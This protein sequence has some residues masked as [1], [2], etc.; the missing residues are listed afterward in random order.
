MVPSTA[1]VPLREPADASPQ[2]EERSAARTARF[3]SFRDRVSLR[4]RHELLATVR[5]RIRVDPSVRVL[6]LGGGAGAATELFAHGAGEIVVLDPD[7]K[8]LQR[9]QARRLG[10]TFTHGVAEALPFPDGRFDRVASVL[11][12]HHFRD[13]RAALAEASRVLAPG[14]MLLVCD[15]EANTW[16]GRLF[17]LFHRATLHGSL[18]F[19]AAAVVDSW[20]ERTGFLRIQRTR[21]G[22]YYLLTAEK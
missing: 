14:G 18:S 17:R 21:M 10:L 20:L 15:V 11:S 13:G 19:V 4:W 6:D 1:N 5:E 12:F 2:I 7:P 8:K 9:G 22:P 16:P 3:L